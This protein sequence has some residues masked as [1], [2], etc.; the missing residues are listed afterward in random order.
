MFTG[1]CKN[2]SLQ[3]ESECGTS[4][5]LHT[6]HSTEKE[7]ALSMSW[8]SRNSSLEDHT[9]F[10]NNAPKKSENSRPPSVINQ[11]VNVDMQDGSE[12]RG[13][14]SPRS[15]DSR[16]VRFTDLGSL[17]GNIECGSF[18]IFLPLRF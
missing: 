5:E 11:N 14:A 16:L 15:Y 2:K 9:K 6:A 1:Y 10:D 18:G 3:Y 13:S 17:I 12:S 7:A 8:L 4:M